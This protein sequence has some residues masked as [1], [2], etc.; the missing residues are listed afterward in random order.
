M[1]QTRELFSGL[2]ALED[3]RVRQ[4]L[5]VGK[6]RAL[7]FGTGFADS[8]VLNAVRTLT[9]KPVDLV[10]TH[11]DRDH[12]G[13]LADFDVCRMHPGDWPLVKDA[14][15]TLMPIYE[16]DIVRCG[17]YRFEVIEIGGHTAGSVAF[18]DHEKKLLIA[19]DSVQQGG[20]IYMF[21]DHRNL[22]AYINSLR[23]LKLLIPADTT[24]LSCHSACPIGG[25]T[26]ALDLADALALRDGALESEPHP[27]LPCRIYHGQTTDFLY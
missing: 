17:S 10:M 7:L 8:G 24:V 20:P 18:Y 27:A 26:I 12:T 6:E 13:G 23:K 25:E 2:Y 19:G 15:T 4:F 14:Q 16:G 5:V 3:E 1:L 22:S 21:G 9:D 11:G